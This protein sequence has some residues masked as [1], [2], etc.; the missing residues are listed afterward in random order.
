MSGWAHIIKKSRKNQPK[1][2]LILNYN[3]IITNYYNILKFYQD[4]RKL[5]GAKKQ[6]K[7]PQVPV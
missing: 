5:P 2:N 4:L 7:F 1:S 3:R 6:Q